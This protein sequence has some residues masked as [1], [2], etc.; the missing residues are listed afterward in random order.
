MTPQQTTEAPQAAILT[1]Q[2]T[3]EASQAA[4]KAPQAAIK[5]PQATLLL[6]QQT[7]EASQAAIKASQAALLTFQIHFKSQ[8]SQKTFQLWNPYKK[9]HPPKPISAEGDASTIKRA[10]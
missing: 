7:T 9:K 2:Q 5:A 8:R 10:I 1:S 6:S 3:T 4:I